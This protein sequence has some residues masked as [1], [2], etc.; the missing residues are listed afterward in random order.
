[1][2]TRRRTT[3]HHQSRHQRRH[4]QSAQCKWESLF[5]KVLTRR[6]LDSDKDAITEKLLQSRQWGTRVTC[7]AEAVALAHLLIEDLWHQQLL[8]KPLAVIQVDPNNCF[9]RLE[10][11]SIDAAVTQDHPAMA[12]FT[13]WKHARTP[14]VAQG[15]TGRRGQD[16]GAQQGDVA[17]PFGA[18]AALAEQARDTRVVIRQAH[19]HGLLPRAN[20]SA[21]PQTQQ[22][23]ALECARTVNQPMCKDNEENEEN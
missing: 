23:R 1:M 13:L 9:G 10:Y 7:G 15:T 22:S 17:G 2:R 8:D 21:D 3:R 12:P 16:R 19:A 5:R 20:H 18:S 6:I 11:T 4:H 14:Q